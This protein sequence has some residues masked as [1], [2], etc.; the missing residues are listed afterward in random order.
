MKTFA[1]LDHNN[2]VTN[3]IVCDSAETADLVTEA[4]C[5]EYTEENVAQIGWIYDPETG[6]F[7][8]PEPPAPSK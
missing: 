6:E 4:I 7:N 8:P 2:V 1:V 3:V 5:I